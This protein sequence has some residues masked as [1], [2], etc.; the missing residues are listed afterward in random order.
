MSDK[1]RKMHGEPVGKEE[2]LK[3]LGNPASWARDERK[4]EFN[5][6]LVPGNKELDIFGIKGC[7]GSE[8]YLGYLERSLG[9]PAGSDTGLVSEEENRVILETTTQEISAE[10][11]KY[12]GLLA[13][14]EEVPAEIEKY[15]GALK[16]TIEIK[17]MFWPENPEAQ[18]IEELKELA[19]QSNA[20]TEREVAEIR[21]TIGA[22]TEILNELRGLY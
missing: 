20:R 21:E 8:G 22:Y 3:A 18:P 15:L 16:R 13:K 14:L 4:L 17:Q 11:E 7:S 19:R 1:R 9:C 5:K 6:R 12:T 10:I 2:V